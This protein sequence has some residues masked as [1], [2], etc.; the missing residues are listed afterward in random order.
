MNLSTYL[1]AGYPGIAIVTAVSPHPESRLAF[2]QRLDTPID[3]S[4][5]VR[6]DFYGLRRAF[7]C[8][9]VFAVE[10]E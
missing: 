9:E 8:F 3:A 2:L 6:S 10:F 4:F 7:D 1:R 5:G